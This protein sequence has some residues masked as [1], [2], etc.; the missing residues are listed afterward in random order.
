MSWR[1]DQ[2]PTKM[3]E[4]HPETTVEMQLP[5]SR[6]EQRHSSR[7]GP[8]P[9]LDKALAEIAELRKLVASTTWEDHGGA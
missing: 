7:A 9:A 4:V 1:V 2:L 6:Y 5:E 8:M 3:A